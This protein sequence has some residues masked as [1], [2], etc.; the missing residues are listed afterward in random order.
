MESQVP[1][2]VSLYLAE[3]DDS[4]L[5]RMIQEAFRETMADA[6]NRMEAREETRHSCADGFQSVQ[7]LSPSPAVIG[8]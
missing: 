3:T 4:A 1:K 6:E 7:S 8:W 5:E 2:S